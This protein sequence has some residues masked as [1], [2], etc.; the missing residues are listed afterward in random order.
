MSRELLSAGV[1]LDSETEREREAR[2]EELKRELVTMAARGDVSALIDKTLGVVLSLERENE[3][4]SWR[5]LR[6]LRYRFGR[7][8]EKL[9]Q[10]ELA[11]FC[12]ALGGTAADA[13]APEPQV[14][15]APLVDAAAVDPPEKE[16]TKTKRNRKKGGAIVL[17]PTVERIVTAVPVVAEERACALCGKDKLPMPPVEHETIEF[18]PARVVVR[19]ERREQ[20]ACA[21]CRK[22]VSVAPRVAPVNERRIGASMHAKLLLDKCANGMPLDRQ[23]RELVRMGADIPANT[24]ASCWAYAT[25]ALEPVALA[26]LADVLASPVLGADDTHLRTLD[27]TAKGG[28]FRGR[29]WCFV[30]TNGEI[31]DQERVA[32]G[33]APSWEAEEIQHWFSS[34]DGFV[35]C[36]AYAGYGAECEG[37]DGETVVAVPDERRLGCMMHVRSKFHA[38]LLGKDHRAAVGLKCIAD[39]YEIEAHCKEAGLDAAARGAVRA[40][41]S[42]PL[43][44]AFD[45]W[46]DALHP[47]LLPRS[48][49]R[50][51]T[52]YAKNQR[53][54]VRRAFEDGRFEIDNGRTERRIRPFAMGRRGFLFTGSVRGGERLAIAYTLVDNCLLLGL[55]PQR[56]LEDVLTKLAAGWPIRRLSELTPHGFLAHH[57]SE[58]GKA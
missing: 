58:Q 3:R 28:I 45:T 18:V 12:L 54:F 29:F 35:Q 32:Y 57:R 44:D 42:L 21:S 40:S 26:T 53:A 37:E 13:A 47:R 48:P 34:V 51:A 17:G 22:D 1:E 33:Y 9:S 7:Q 46:V 24:I 56:Y 8:T 49:L 14:P 30:G 19:V 38:A 2:L 27:R 36:D 31:G 10:E 23:R 50:Q 55:D 39:L 15:V 6:A 41:R 16:K 20:L 52:Q 11:Q 5:L 25:D 43:L 4:L